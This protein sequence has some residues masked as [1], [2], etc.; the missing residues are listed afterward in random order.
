MAARADESDYLAANRLTDLN[1]D[2]EVKQILLKVQDE[3]A[4]FANLQT[5]DG[6]VDSKALAQQ[7]YGTDT[8]GLSLQDASAELLRSLQLNKFSLKLAGSTPGGAD[9]VAAAEFA[10][11]QREADAK[12]S[13]AAAALPSS[14]MEPLMMSHAAAHEY[15]RQFWASVL[16]SSGGGNS[17]VQNIARFL[18]KTPERVEAIANEAKEAGYSPEYVHNVRLHFDRLRQC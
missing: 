1:G 13:S 5:D 4:F 8:A 14:I 18:Q 10:R 16:S 6:G 11:M 12:S 3:H 7:S 15:L 2:P 9:K 17:N